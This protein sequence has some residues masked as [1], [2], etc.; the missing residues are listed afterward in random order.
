VLISNE[1][2]AISVRSGTRVDG[3]LGADWLAGLRVTIDYPG[4]RLWIGPGRQPSPPSG[5]TQ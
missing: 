3:I 1:L 4:G 2:A 5:P